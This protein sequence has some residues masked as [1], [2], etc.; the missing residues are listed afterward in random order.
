MFFLLLNDDQRHRCSKKKFIS[1]FFLFFLLHFTTGWNDFSI[2]YLIVRYMCVSSLS[3][4]VH[5]IHA[6]SQCRWCKSMQFI[7]KFFSHLSR[8]PVNPAGQKESYSKSVLKKLFA[9]LNT[10]SLPFI[11]LVYIAF[12]DDDFYQG[13]RLVFPEW[14]ADHYWS[15]STRRVKYIW[16]IRNLKNKYIKK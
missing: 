2:V 3:M 5:M 6:L 13:F 4:C 8:F 11:E 14:H 15:L 9:I 12:Y 1:N 16:N 10:F 7:F